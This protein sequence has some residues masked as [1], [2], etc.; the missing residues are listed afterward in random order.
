MVSKSRNPTTRQDCA[1]RRVRSGNPEP[2]FSFS[3]LLFFQL[4][5]AS[6]H[7]L[8]DKCYRQGLV[9]G[10]VDSALR[11][12]QVFEFVLE[13]CDDSGG[14]EQAA[15]IGKGGEPHHDTALGNGGNAIADGFRSAGGHGGADGGPE[16]NEIAAGG[17][18]NASLVTVNVAGRSFYARG[19]F[20]GFFGR[21]HAR[22]NL[23]LCFRQGAR[24]QSQEHGAAEAVTSRPT[25]A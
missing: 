6:F 25:R 17:W 5:D 13:L 16:L 4:S 15:M 10:K 9:V 21:R 11:S 18:G 14:G 22:E 20:S 12:A 24:L 7:H 19:G 3:S 2:A 1:S 23:R 8:A